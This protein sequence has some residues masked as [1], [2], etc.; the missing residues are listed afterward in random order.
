MLFKDHIISKKSLVVLIF[1]ITSFVICTALLLW[2]HYPTGSLG[3]PKYNDHARHMRFAYEFLDRGTHIYDTLMFDF[4]QIGSPYAYEWPNIVYLYPLGCVLFFL[5][6]GLLAFGG[7]VSFAKVA[8]LLVWLFLLIAHVNTLLLYYFLF[9]GKAEK[10][11]RAIFIGLFYIMS[12]WWAFHGQYESLV[13]LPLLLALFCRKEENR[14]LLL[15]TSFFL[16]LQAI[17]FWPVFVRQWWHI[18][19]QKLVFSWQ[20]L[21]AYIMIALNCVMIYKVAHQLIPRVTNPIH[22][23]TFFHSFGSMHILILL[24]T[25]AF[26]IYFWAR[27]RWW[28]FVMFLSQMTLL[29]IVGELQGWYLTLLFVTPIFLDTEQDQHLYMLWYM[30]FL[31]IMSLLFAPPVMLD[32]LLKR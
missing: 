6:F 10:F 22:I 31:W 5:P 32:L 4:A 28:L 12:T 2:H 30:L 27:K 14:L 9:R 13:A 24:L 11:L 23:T 15:I 20:L 8:N 18:Y 7:V 21:V 29:V 25:A 19:K 1:L 17:F 26:G 3:F 16:K